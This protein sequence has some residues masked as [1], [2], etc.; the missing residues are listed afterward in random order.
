MPSL[1]AGYNGSWC[2]PVEAQEH[3]AMCYRK[4]GDDPR[5]DAAF[6]KF[7]ELHKEHMAPAY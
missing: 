5:A 7:M 4:M 2:E 3:L 1:P 6:K